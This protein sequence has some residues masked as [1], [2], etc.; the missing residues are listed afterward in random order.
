MADLE[1]IENYCRNCVSR[2]FVTGRGL[3]C[4]RTG[5]IPA[6]E[7]A[8]ES[9]E[10]DEELEKIAPTPHPDGSSDYVSR[11]QLLSE[12][13]LPKAVLW[14]V[15]ASLV[16]AVVWGLVSVS[17][18]YQIGYMAIGVG[19][20]VGLAMRRG[21]GITPVFGVI[22]ALLALVSCILG[23]F[24]SIVGYAA[25]EYDM[26]YIDTLISVD[27]NEIFS[28]MIENVVSMTAL[29]Y[30]IAVYEGYKLSFRVQK[31]RESGMI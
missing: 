22:G 4:K 5:S 29:F 11:E 26:S 2:N 10:K 18:G 13:N 27:Y 24:F 23:D 1:G 31:Q 6:F 16:G 14:G 20:L 25:Q 30:G 15:I 3:V 9:Y 17:T 12:E 7:E 19:F 28:I 8:C 21:K